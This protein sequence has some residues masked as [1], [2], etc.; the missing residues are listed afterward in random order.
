MV[1]TM[2]DPVHNVETIC[3]LCICSFLAASYY[4]KDFQML[5]AVNS[6]QYLHKVNDGEI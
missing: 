3:V 4:R 5:L 1:A 2:Y 6:K